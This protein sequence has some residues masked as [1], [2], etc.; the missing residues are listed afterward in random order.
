MKISLLYKFPI[1]ESIPFPEEATADATGKLF[2]CNKYVFERQMY[3]FFTVQLCSHYVGW[4]EQF[5]GNA[6]MIGTFRRACWYQWG[7]QFLPCARVPS[8]G[9]CLVSEMLDISKETWWG[10]CNLCAFDFLSLCTCIVGLGQD[11]ASLVAWLILKHEHWYG[12]SAWCLMTS[13]VLRIWRKISIHLPQ[14]S[15]IAF[16]E[17]VL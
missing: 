5:L 8:P 15:L 17:I 14:K 7:E 4:T 13:K 12:S 9:V 6:C 10:A 11:G 3:V 2:I 16:K 1:H